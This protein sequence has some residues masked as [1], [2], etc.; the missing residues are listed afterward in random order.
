MVV[1]SFQLVVMALSRSLRD[2][3][4]AH[5]LSSALSTSNHDLDALFARPIPPRLLVVLWNY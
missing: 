3:P 1:L 5:I 4:F 2:S